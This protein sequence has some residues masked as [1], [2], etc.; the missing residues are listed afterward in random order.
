M[1][2]MLRALAALLLVTAC[3][4][5]P[6]EDID[7]QRFGGPI[8]VLAHGRDYFLRLPVERGPT[9]VGGFKVR[10]SGDDLLVY[11]TRFLEANQAGTRTV[12]LRLPD[13]LAGADL[14]GR[15]YWLDPDGTQHRLP[16]SRVN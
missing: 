5:E 6:V 1:S 16:V 13:E 9:M 15:L 14:T 10:R 2:T 3:A 11:P 12:R 4:S 8:E 7:S